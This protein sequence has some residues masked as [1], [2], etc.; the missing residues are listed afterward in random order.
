MMNI[1]RLRYLLSLI[2]ICVHQSKGSEEVC[3]CTVLCATDLVNTQGPGYY[4]SNN[5]GCLQLTTNC[6]LSSPLCVFKSQSECKSSCVQQQQPCQ[7][8]PSG[9]CPD[10]QSHRGQCPGE[11]DAGLPSS[12]M[13]WN[14][15]SVG[16][17]G[18]ILALSVL[19][20][21]GLAVY[22]RHKH[23]KRKRTRYIKEVMQMYEDVSSTD[24]LSDSSVDDNPD[25]N[26][27]FERL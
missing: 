11:T 25:S 12:A 13:R 20:I 5:G 23:K 2:L 17:V 21:S 3:T 22:Y 10:G 7:D 14:V 19:S 16:V 24:S 8:S 27:L 9:C 26:N 15:V 4:F 1:G 18:S 6:S